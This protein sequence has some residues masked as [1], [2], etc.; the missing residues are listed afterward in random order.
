MTLMAFPFLHL[1]SLLSFHPSPTPL[2]AGT[3]NAERN[4]WFLINLHFTFPILQQVLDPWSMRVEP[5]PPTFL[6]QVVKLP[7]REWQHTFTDFLWYCAMAL[8]VCWRRRWW[9]GEV[10]YK[11]RPVKIQGG[12]KCFKIM[13][14]YVANINSR[15]NYKRRQGF[16]GH[17][18]VGGLGVEG[19]GSDYWEKF[20][21]PS[22]W[23]TTRKSQRETKKFSINQITYQTE[24][25][26]AMVAHRINLGCP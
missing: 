15:S 17:T 1:A 3:E 10:S 11:I 18:N 6:F 5:P 23:T 13:F 24:T 2:Q 16:P 8:A 21:I 9:S 4:L 22:Q 25:K 14:N 7:N 12:G 20:G 19:K 26:V